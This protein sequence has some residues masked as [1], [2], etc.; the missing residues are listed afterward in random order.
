MQSIILMRMLLR[1]IDYQNNNYH[2]NTI[3]TFMRKLNQEMA[4]TSLRNHL[5]I[6]MSI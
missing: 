2:Q 5:I 1:I 6:I 4:S 3:N